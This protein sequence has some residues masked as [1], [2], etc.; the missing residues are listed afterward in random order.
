MS[1]SSLQRA[2]L[3]NKYLLVKRALRLTGHRVKEIDYE[4][5]QE[6]VTLEA[7]EA[8]LKAPTANGANRKSWLKHW[9]KR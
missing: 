7:I 5:L 2:L 6:S 3:R 4:G 9:F 8:K 1:A